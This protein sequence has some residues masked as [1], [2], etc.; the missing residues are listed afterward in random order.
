MLYI[1]NFFQSNIFS[2]LHNLYNYHLYSTGLIICLIMC[3]VLRHSGF[4]IGCGGHG[5]YY[6]HLYGSKYFFR[7][8]SLEW[9]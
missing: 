3:Q 2:L 8:I 9:D 6:R 4:Q 7:I 1:C 5:D